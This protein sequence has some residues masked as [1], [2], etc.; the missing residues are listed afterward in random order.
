VIK[1]A[2]KTQNITADDLLVKSKLTASHQ[3]TPK[4]SA[5][6]TEV[7][8]YQKDLVNYHNHHRHLCWVVSQFSADF[9][10]HCL[11]CFD[12]WSGIR[13]IIQPVKN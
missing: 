13:K 12:S 1:I 4:S 3:V 8:L 11:Q 5:I 2:L 10:F 9:L 6:K 7:Q